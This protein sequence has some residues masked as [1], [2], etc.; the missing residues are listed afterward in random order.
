MIKSCL[1][2]AMSLCMTQLVQAQIPDFSTPKKSDKEKTHFIELGMNANWL[3]RQVLPAEVNANIPEMS[4]YLLTARWGKDSWAFRFGIGGRYALDEIQ[5]EGF[6]DKETFKESNI[7][8]RIGFEK[9]YRLGKKLVASLG[10]D[11]VAFYDNDEESVDSG[12]D[13]VT[14]AERQKGIGA[15]PVIGLSYFFT[16]R[17]ACFVEGG[18]MAEFSQTES[19]RLFQN[20]PQFDDEISRVN[21]TNITVNL[22]ATF[23]FAFFF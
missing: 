9:R 22:P 8:L 6:G 23:Y 21:S 1:L 20:F 13:V 4:S 11:A 5:L 3:I 14:V 18:L 17:F 10:L 19:A 12:F 7:D 15:G 2:L 16:P